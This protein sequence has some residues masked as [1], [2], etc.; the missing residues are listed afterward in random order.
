MAKRLSDL[1]GATAYAT[2]N[3]LC[4][5]SR[6]LRTFEHHSLLTADLKLQKSWKLLKR[7][8][9]S[10]GAELVAVEGSEGGWTPTAVGARR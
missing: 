9:L 5:C 3:P 10:L 1:S 2:G 7:T 4:R 8:V 6:L